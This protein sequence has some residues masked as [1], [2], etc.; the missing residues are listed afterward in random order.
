MLNWRVS[1]AVAVVAAV[2]LTV[3]FVASCQ[4]VGNPLTPATEA[5]VALDQMIQDIDLLYIVNRLDLQQAQLAPLLEVTS[6]LQAERDKLAPRRQAAIGELLPALREKRALLLQ[7]KEVTPEIEGRIRAAQGRMDDLENELRDAA[8]KHVPEL[9][10]VLTP[11]QVSIITGEDEAQAQAEELLQWIRELPAADFAEEAKAN[12]EELA[13]P[14]LNLTAD[15]IMKIFNDARKLSEQ[16]YNKQ[17]ATFVKRL[18]PLYMPMED[19]A[20]ESL[21]EFLGSPRLGAIIKEKM[22]G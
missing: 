6:R 18:A 11:E 10:K 15:V 3:C 22:G 19:A 20:D 13:D 2:S 21:L 1:M 7:D 16:D 8:A 5:D 9:K 12:A 4:P 14:E 17:K